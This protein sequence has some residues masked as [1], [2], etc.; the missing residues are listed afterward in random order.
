M[1]HPHEPRPAR[2]TWRRYARAALAIAG[3]ALGL[4]WAWNASAAVLFGAPAL[5]FKHAL[6]AELLLVL[7]G[8]S[9]QIGV[10]PAAWPGRAPE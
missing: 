1:S 3:G 4:L 2:L 6:A 10:R 9:A 8:W 7:A 5:Q